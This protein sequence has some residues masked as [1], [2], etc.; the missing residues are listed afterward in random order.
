MS[1]NR[2]LGITTTEG[3]QGN[4]GT[5][6]QRAFC[7][8]VWGYGWRCAHAH[9]QV[10]LTGDWR[11]TSGWLYPSS[12]TRIS[13]QGLS[14]SSLRAVPGP[15]CLHGS[16]E[17][18]VRS[19]MP[20]FPR[21]KKTSIQPSHRSGTIVPDRSGTPMPWPM[22]VYAYVFVAIIIYGWRLKK[23]TFR[24]GLSA[25]LCTST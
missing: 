22:L 25:L 12:S 4:K 9:T 15:A 5:R 6:S 13:A 16:P 8:G 20:G 18:Q 19:T 10:H 1:Q 2:K 21:G 23:L 17:A 24:F 11:L 7:F 3:N 14:L